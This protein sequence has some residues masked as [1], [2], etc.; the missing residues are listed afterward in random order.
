MQKAALIQP[1]SFRSGETNDL[2]IL[3]TNDKSNT[4][5]LKTI[6]VF[7]LDP[8]LELYPTLPPMQKKL[9]LGCTRESQ[10]PLIGRA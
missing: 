8:R 1:L 2:R 5:L 4:Y 6:L 3:H 9:T 7:G 10:I